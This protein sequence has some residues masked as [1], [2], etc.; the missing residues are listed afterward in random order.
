MSDLWFTVSGPIDGTLQE[1]GWIEGRGF[2]GDEHAGMAALAAIYRREEICATPTGPC[3]IA[4]DSPVHVALLTALSI[5][6]RGSRRI[7]LEGTAL[8]A[9]EATLADLVRLPEGTV[10]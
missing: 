4:A 2:S 8:P 9:A 7:K 3:F 5:F 1:I 6:D 10:A